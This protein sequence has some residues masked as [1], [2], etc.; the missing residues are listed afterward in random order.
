MAAF[1][2]GTLRAD[3]YVGATGQLLLGVLTWVALAAALT[4]VAP[5]SRLQVALVVGVATVFEVVGSLVWGLYTYRLDNLPPFVPPGHGLV[6]I[7]GLSLAAAFSRRQGMLVG[8]AVAG[9]GLW[10]I[11]GLTLL[12]QPDVGGA[13]GALTLML[14]LVLVRTRRAV[15]AGM[16]V[17][18]AALELYGTAVG[19]WT[20]AGAVPHLGIATANPPSGAASGYVLFD[21]AAAFA[22]ARVMTLVGTRRATAS[23]AASRFRFRSPPPQP[24]Q[25]ESRRGLGRPSGRSQVSGSTGRP[26][27][28]ARAAPRSVRTAP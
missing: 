27:T 3:H 22:A 13:L 17:V 10:G 15:Y 21:I 6:F 25:P 24:P 7:A 11:L 4:Q 5:E 16:F 14:T 8:L 18:V 1:T 19:A 9:V 2:A 20:W 26:A 28:A 23:P 12:P